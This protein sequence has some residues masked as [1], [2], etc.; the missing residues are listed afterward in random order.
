MVGAITS[1]KNRG[2]AEIEK[3]YVMFTEGRKEVRKG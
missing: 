1:L 2:L 3:K